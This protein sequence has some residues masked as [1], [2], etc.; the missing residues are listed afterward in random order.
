M[1]LLFLGTAITSC[2]EESNLCA[3]EN[4]VENLDWLKELVAEATVNPEQAKYEYYKRALY[5]GD[6]IFYYGNCNPAINYVA[7]VYNCEGKLIGYI[8]DFYDDLVDMDVVW[9][10]EDTLCTL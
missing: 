6:I 4:P 5:K 2:D 1:V 9:K 10:A 7:S 3:G 8:E